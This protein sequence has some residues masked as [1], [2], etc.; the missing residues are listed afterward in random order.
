MA[1]NEALAN[2][3]NFVLSVGTP[4]KLRQDNPK[5]FLLEH[6]DLYCL[7]TGILPAKII[8]ETPQLKLPQD[9]AGNVKMLAHWIGTS[10]DGVRAVIVNEGNQKLG[11]E[12]RRR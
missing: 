2:L 10:Q 8:P 12:M 11:F 5:E 6:F 4:R 1:K 7:D 9:T 3:K